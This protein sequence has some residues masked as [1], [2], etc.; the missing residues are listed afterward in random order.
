MR[1]V[2][3]GL[4]YLLGS[5]VVLVGGFVAYCAIDGI[6]HFKPPVVDVH[7]DLTPERVARGKK[8]VSL[9]CAECHKNPTTGKLTGKRMED[10]PR[11][12]GELHSRNITKS[13]AHGIGAWKD[14]EIVGLLRTGIARDGRYTPPW[15][16]KLPHMSDED[17]Y[18]IIAFLRSDDPMVAAS[19]EPSIA[20]KTSLLSKVLA[21]T[22]FRPLPMPTTVQTA[23]AKTDK[24]A[25][26]RY[27]V[28]HALECYSCHS[29]DFK[30]MNVDEPEKSPGFLGG[31]NALV[32]LSQEKVYSANITFDEETGIGKWSEANLKR[33]LRDG[34]RPD[35]TLVRYPMEPMRDL[36]DDDVA[37]IYAY[38]QQVPKIHKR[39][40]PNPPLA[41]AAGASDGQ[42]IYYKYGCNSCHGERGVGVGDLRPA[43]KKYA[44]DEA[45]SKWIRNAPSIKPDTKM[46][47]W[48]GV[49]AEGEYAPLV[50]YVRQLGQDAERDGVSAGGGG[51]TGR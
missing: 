34:I 2:L 16:A 29:A 12:F 33:A 1:K 27:L 19:E 25:Y 49:I 10:A 51:T 48:D 32:G 43:N 8:L 18:S 14:G 7:V 3:K 44:T 26:G 22:V 47:T 9:L 30:T 45:L 40:H 37:A 15:M 4:G 50:K 6:P 38:L 39:R 28:T 41:L 17:V 36:E 24:V 21:H 35:N 42:K 20:C 46:P 31:D 23:P 13:V 11:E 5:V